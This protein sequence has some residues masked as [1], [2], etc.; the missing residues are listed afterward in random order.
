MELIL[1]TEEE[2]KPVR[3]II[4]SQDKL[5]L[6][7]G[8][9]FVFTVEVIPSDATNK[10]LTWNST[11]TSVATVDASGRVTTVP[12]GTA[13]GLNKHNGHYVNQ[14]SEQVKGYCKYLEQFHE[15]VVK[16]DANVSGYTYITQK[17]N[18]APCVNAPNV[19]LVRYDEVPITVKPDRP[20]KKMQSK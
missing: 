7:E 10:E 11:N 17:T 16:K 1:I 15:M 20:K 9:T 14:P 19:D 6:V 13:D 4:L 5:S 3:D 2:S 18:L 12:A 8:E